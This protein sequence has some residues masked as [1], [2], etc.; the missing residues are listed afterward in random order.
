M[1]EIIKSGIMLRVSTTIHISDSYLPGYLPTSSGGMKA[2][3]TQ[4]ASTWNYISDAVLRRCQ[5]LY[6][7]VSCAHVDTHKCTYTYVDAYVHTHTPGMGSLCIC[8]CTCTLKYQYFTYLYLVFK[9]QE[10]LYLYL[11]LILGCI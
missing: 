1:E 7:R 3:S 4:H 2:I 9:I 11:I 5:H 6:F 8:T 10:Y